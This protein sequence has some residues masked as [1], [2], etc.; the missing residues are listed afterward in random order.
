MALD[1][2][3]SGIGSDFTLSFAQCLTVVAFLTIALYNVVELTILIFTK[4]RQYRGIYFYALVVASWGIVPYSVAFILK[5][6]RVPVHWGVIVAFIDIGW[7]CMVTGQSV[8]L[9]S[10]IHLISRGVIA[11]GRWI[12]YMIITNAIICHIPVVIILTGANSPNPGPY[13]KPYAIAERIQVSIFFIQEVIISGIYVQQTMKMLQSEGSIRA[14]AK[15]VMT[16]LILVNV[17][18]VLLDISMLAFEFAGLYSFQVSYKA[19]VYSIKLKMEFAILN[20][21]V[22]MV[23]G[24]LGDSSINN[25]PRASRKRTGSSFGGGFTMRSEGM[26]RSGFRTPLTGS[27]GKN[28]TL[29]NSAY[30]KMED[31]LPA[32]SLAEMGVV[33]TTEVSVETSARDPQEMSTL[34]DAMADATWLK[35]WEQHMP[36]PAHCKPGQSSSQDSIIIS[37]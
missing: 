18:I 35:D 2:R 12:L 34:P 7:P 10:R 15:K 36:T 25:N 33:K 4:F 3:D 28:S 32:I 16:H 19:A 13:L 22:A 5:F 37:I 21:L 14:S 11:R 8:V 27:L 1:S 24:R 6:F 31:T 23:Q 30:A 17:F 26:K 29:G 20:R 9:Y